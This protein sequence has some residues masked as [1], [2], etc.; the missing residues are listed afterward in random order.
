[1]TDIVLDSLKRLQS[2]IDHLMKLTR[3]Q[4]ADWLTV[5]HAALTC[6][7]SY[8]HIYRTVQSGELPAADISNGEKKAAYRIRR[9]D[10]VLKRYGGNVCRL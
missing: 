10:L 7:C 6:D 3:L 1:V 9:A 2:Q 4:V 8:D 5:E